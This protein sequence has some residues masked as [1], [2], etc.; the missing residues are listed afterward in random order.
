MQDW[1]VFGEMP[2]AGDC[3]TIDALECRRADMLKFYIKGL[4]EFATRLNQSPA[5]PSFEYHDGCP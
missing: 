4:P 1:D 3:A 2:I 5:L